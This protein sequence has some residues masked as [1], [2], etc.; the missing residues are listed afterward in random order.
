MGTTIQDFATGIKY[1]GETSSSQ[2]RT[3]VIH[4]IGGSS[5]KKNK[6]LNNSVHLDY[7]N[8]NITHSRGS[9]NAKY[10]RWDGLDEHIKEAGCD[11]NNNC[12]IQYCNE[13]HPDYNMLYECWEGVK[14]GN[15]NDATGEYGVLDEPYFQDNFKLW[16]TNDNMNSVSSVEAIHYDIVTDCPTLHGGDVQDCSDPTPCYSGDIDACGICDDNLFNDNETCTGCT[17]IDACNYDPINLIVGILGTIVSPP[18]IKNKDFKTNSTPSSKDIQNL[19][20]SS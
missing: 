4:V 20:I 11:G 19:V 7:P 8:F 2:T 15:L 10:N 13:S 14:I 9:L 12:S 1:F 17:D 3:N 6:F 5:S 18:F 16:Y